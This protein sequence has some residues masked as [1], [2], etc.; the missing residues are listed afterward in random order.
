M[1]QLMTSTSMVLC[2]S[3]IYHRLTIYFTQILWVMTVQ[4]FSWA[5]IN[6]L[7]SRTSQIIN[8]LDT[9]SKKD[10]ETQFSLKIL[11]QAADNRC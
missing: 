7:C 3:K 2:S 5:I 8:F 10:I 1:F 11:I 4:D 9:A 6:E